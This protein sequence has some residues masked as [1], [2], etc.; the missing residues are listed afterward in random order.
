MLGLA[1]ERRR[2][3][4][5]A[6]QA[7]VAAT[8]EPVDEEDM[9]MDIDD[10]CAE[11]GSEAAR[12]NAELKEA[13]AE[14]ARY[15]TELEVEDWGKALEWLVGKCTFCAGRGYSGADL[16]HTLRR[17]TKG[18]ARQ[19]RQGIGEM[20]Y[21]EGFAPDNGCDY[22]RLPRELCT[23]RWKKT[24]RGSWVRTPISTPLADRYKY[25]S[26]LLCDGVIGFYACGEFWLKQD[27]LEGVIEY[28]EREGE[29]P[30]FDDEAAASWLVQPLL[31]AGVKASEMVR[32]LCSWTNNLNEFTAWKKGK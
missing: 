16:R 25:G 12:C 11:A 9:N 1:T 21:D 20:F 31:I 13:E 18:D 5:L 10:D 22:C 23:T 29:E 24:D 14:A 19:V 3:R 8:A 32:L 27:V 30:T 28:C 26:T 7:L 2:Q 17:Y 15:N 6:K 4:R